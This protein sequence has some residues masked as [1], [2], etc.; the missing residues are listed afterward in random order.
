MPLGPGTRIGSYEITTL[1]GEG[2]MGQVY[3]ARDTKLNRDVALKV[4]P[5]LVANDPDRLA[6][7][8]RE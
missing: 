8:R 1:I 6:R 4:L 7:F 3:R 5:P 2:G